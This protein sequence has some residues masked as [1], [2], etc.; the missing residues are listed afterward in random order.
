MPTDT[1]IELKL[2]KSSVELLDLSGRNR[3]INTPRTRSKSTS[4]EIVDADADAVYRRLVCD[5]KSFTFAAGKGEESEDE[6]EPGVLRLAQ[7][8]DDESEPGVEKKRR[9]DTLHTLLKSEIL[10]RRLLRLFY[11]AR[12]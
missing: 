10:Q 5:K 7:P 1:A 9:P 8:D 6:L 2:R 4:I 12:T 11:D 3:L